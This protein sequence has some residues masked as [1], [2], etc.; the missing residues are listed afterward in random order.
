MSRYPLLYF[1]LCALAQDTVDCEKVNRKSTYVPDN[2]Y[3]TTEQSWQT[4]NLFSHSNIRPKKDTRLTTQGNV[5]Q[6]TKSTTSCKFRIEFFGGHLCEKF[7]GSTQKRSLLRWTVCS[8]AS[9]ATSSA[10]S[11]KTSWSVSTRQ[12]TQRACSAGFQ[13]S[14][15]SGKTTT[16]K[17]LWNRR[18]CI[19][20]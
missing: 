2:T 17:S 6:S 12:L 1:C 3:A 10:P 19:H 5:T 13:F 11:T 7:L 15:P 14:S 9:E 4:H 20:C 16:F 8:T 18:G